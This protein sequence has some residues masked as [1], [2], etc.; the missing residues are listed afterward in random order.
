MNNGWTG[1]M[2]EYELWANMNN[3]WIWIMGKNES[4]I[5][6]RIMGEFELWVNFCWIQPECDGG[7]A[8]GGQDQFLIG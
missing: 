6:I 2:G 4:W 8:G 3:L 7:A 1:I 5:I